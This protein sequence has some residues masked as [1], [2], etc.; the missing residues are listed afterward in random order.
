MFSA[1]Y[2]AEQNLLSPQETAELLSCLFM[3][4]NDLAPVDDRRLALGILDKL[5]DN[6]LKAFSIPYLVHASIAADEAGSFSEDILKRLMDGCPEVDLVPALSNSTALTGKL[7]GYIPEPCMENAAPKKAYGKEDYIDLERRRGVIFLLSALKELPPAS[8]AEILDQDIWEEFLHNALTNRYGRYA[9]VLAFSAAEVSGRPVHPKEYQKIL[10][11]KGFAEQPDLVYAFLT[12]YYSGKTANEIVEDVLSNGRKILYASR[13]GERINQNKQDIPWFL[14]DLDQQQEDPLSF[15]SMLWEYTALLIAIR[16]AVR[17]SE[18]Y[19]TDALKHTVQRLCEHWQNSLADERFGDLFPWLKRETPIYF[20]GDLVHFKNPNKEYPSLFIN[21]KQI[22]AFKVFLA[23]PILSMLILRLGPDVPD[24]LAEMSMN[25]ADALTS[26]NIKNMLLRNSQYADR[27]QYSR[28]VL[29][30]IAFS[31]E[32]C[33]AIG[34]GYLN[35]RIPSQYLRLIEERSLPLMRGEAAALSQQETN[36]HSGTSL[37]LCIYMAYEQGSAVLPWQKNTEAW[38]AVCPGEPENGITIAERLCQYAVNEFLYFIGQSGIYPDGYR[39]QDLLGKPISLIY[40]R[41]PDSISKPLYDGA[42]D[43]LAAYEGTDDQ[44][45]RLTEA[46]LL[47]YDQNDAESWRGVS[48]S[49]D[50]SDYIGN[51]HKALLALCKKIQSIAEDDYDI[52]EDDHA[53]LLAWG[54]VYSH[55]FQ[56]KELSRNSR[57]LTAETIDKLMDNS[58]FFRAAKND[59]NRLNNMENWSQTGARDLIQIASETVI[60]TSSETVFYQYKVGE[61]LLKA[62]L[63]QYAASKS[64]VLIAVYSLLLYQQ[65]NALSLPDDQISMFHR[66]EIEDAQKGRKQILQWFIGRLV[67]LMTADNEL[68]T[69]IRSLH[70]RWRSQMDGARK[71]EMRIT[72]DTVITSN[73][74]KIKGWKYWDPDTVN[75]NGI[76]P[77]GRFERL[78]TQYLEGELKPLE[79]DF[80]DLLVDFCDRLSQSEIKLILIEADSDGLLVS[81]RPGVNYRLPADVWEA[82]GYFRLL[83]TLES[84]RETSSS[85]EGLYLFVTLSFD[86]G[87]PK[88]NFIRSDDA[89]LRYRDLFEYDE[90]IELEGGKPKETI[91]R[92]GFEITVIS[93]NGQPLSTSVEVLDN[94]WSEADRR[95][96]CITV[97]NL[98]SADHTLNCHDCSETDVLKKYI[99]LARGQI[100]TIVNIARPSANSENQ[101]YTFAFTEEGMPVR[102]AIESLALNQYL[103]KRNVAR[104]YAL[105]AVTPET[106]TKPNGVVWRCSDNGVLTVRILLGDGETLELPVSAEDLGV[107]PRSVYCGLPVTYDP[108]AGTVKITQKLHGVN[109]NRTSR[110]VVRRLWPMKES[111]GSAEPNVESVYIGAYYL[112]GSSGKTYLL[113]DLRNGRLLSC[114]KD[115]VNPPEDRCGVKMAAG[116]V[117]IRHYLMQNSIAEFRTEERHFYG[118]VENRDKM[119]S[120]PTSYAKVAIRLKEYA[121]PDGAALF[122]IQRFYSEPVR[123]SARSPVVKNQ[124][125][126]KAESY[127]RAYKEWRNSEYWMRDGDL[128]I[129]GKYAADENGGCFVPQEPLSHLPKNISTITDKDPD[130]WTDRIPMQMVRRPVPADQETVFSK[131]TISQNDSYVAVPE[132][133]ARFSLT[134]LQSWLSRNAPN[135]Q[136]YSNYPLF[137]VETV[138]EEGSRILI[139]ELCLGFSIGVSTECFVIHPMRKGDH[140]NLLFYGDSLKRYRL[141]KNRDGQLCLFVSPDDIQLSVEHQIEYDTKLGVIQYMQVHYDPERDLVQPLKITVRSPSLASDSPQQIKRIKNCKL[142]E[143]ATACVKTNLPEGGD[144]FLTVRRTEWDGVSLRQFFTLAPFSEMNGSILCLHGGD[145]EPTASENDYMVTFTPSPEFLEGK[146]LLGDEADYRVIVNRRSFSYNEGALRVYYR[147][148]KLDA[149]RGDMLVKITG[150]GRKPKT[151]LGTLKDNPVHIA[152]SV[153]RWLEDQGSQSVVLGGDGP[154]DTVRIEISPGVFCFASPRGEMHSGVTG[155]LF[156]D[157]GRVFAEAVSD[158]DR[159]FC[160]DGRCVDLLMLDQAVSCQINPKIKTDEEKQQKAAEAL[161]KMPAH[162]SVAGLPQILIE[163]PDLALE[164]I[165]YR[166][167]RLGVLRKGQGLKV[168]A[169]KPQSVLFGCLRAEETEPTEPSKGPL[170]RFTMYKVHPE[171]P[172]RVDYGQISFFDGSME[173]LWQHIR[174]GS[175]HYHDQRTVVMRRNASPY[176]YEYGTDS[177]LPVIMAPGPTLR[178]PYEDLAMYAFPPHEPQEYGL[179]FYKGGIGARFPVA[180]CEKDGIYVEL[181]P[182]RIVRFSTK[183]LHLPGADSD[184]VLCTDYLGTGD[185][186]VLTAEEGTPGTPRSILINKI[187]CG[188]RGL[189]RQNAYLPVMDTGKGRLL[190]GNRFFQMKYPFVGCRYSA[191]DVLMIDQKNHLHPQPGFPE[192]GDLVFAAP[193]ENNGFTVAGFPNCSASLSETGTHLWCNENSIIHR[194]MFNPEKRKKLFSLFGS[195]I[196]M[197]VENAD[198]ESE[199]L[200]LSYPQPNPPKPNAVFCAQIVGMLDDVRILMRAGAFLFIV[201]LSVELGV[202]RELA[203]DIAAV[204]LENSAFLPGQNLWCQFTGTAFSLRTHNQTSPVC[205]INLMFALDSKNGSGFLC[206]DIENRQLRWLPLHETVYSDY[207]NARTI[208]AV[209]QDYAQ[210]KPLKASISK[211]GTISWI[212]SDPSLR[213]KYGALDPSDKKKTIS[214][215]VCSDDLFEEWDEGNRH[216]YLCRERP[217]GNLYALRSELPKYKD[218][219]VH[220]VCV[221][222]TERNVELIPREEQRTTIRLS[223]GMIEKLGQSYSNRKL[224]RK[225]LIEQYPS[226]PEAVAMISGDSTAEDADPMTALFA[227]YAEAVRLRN[228]QIGPGDSRSRKLDANTLAALT[229]YYKHIKDETHIPLTAAIAV[230]ALISRQKPLHANKILQLLMKDVSNYCSEAV[231]LEEWMLWD[232]GN[233]GIYDLRKLLDELD[234]QGKEMNDKQYSDRHAGTLTVSQMDSL[235]AICNTIRR[236]YRG[237]EHHDIARVAICLQYVVLQQKEGFELKGIWRSCSIGKIL[238]SNQKAINNIGQLFEETF[239]EGYKEW[240]SSPLIHIGILKTDAFRKELVSFL[241]DSGASFSEEEV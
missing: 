134:D 44:K 95:R 79:L 191:G 196:P 22:F 165:H 217:F 92:D 96:R 195:N 1:W 143:A 113:Q 161:R 88:L 67:P 29:A 119:V 232:T 173:E 152:K 43:W 184:A 182:G 186:V 203:V 54:E 123:I 71:L 198:P 85:V 223:P 229:T 23:V 2:A 199:T 33:D 42:Q 237:R 47:I 150:D 132:E 30:L 48:F 81:A 32:L 100:V 159:R 193:D 235:N 61:A 225:L 15:I 13:E 146:P 60:D 34:K 175:W 213:E 94:T 101:E 75:A 108:D 183:M 115:A 218:E 36:L 46:D 178:Y 215:I 17:E 180:A 49:G 192:K 137:Y 83:Q 12:C 149:F 64:F 188:L 55:I 38:Y 89:N 130:A 155:K 116:K 156:L 18:R 140:S 233:Y 121:A 211:F 239:W 238:F 50:R 11:T 6:N 166:P 208:F 117:E 204:L 16:K 131:L 187:L 241:K 63:D 76:N 206:R 174:R 40:E 189:F 39:P 98:K 41:F 164:M 227:L 82:E 5:P 179:P 127:Y 234:L 177:D 105:V 128:Y 4:E 126:R 221:K 21:K 84:L 107:T 106:D 93:V 207:A 212:E 120:G 31:S 65:Q 118:H 73:N 181:S 142:D 216:L 8:A 240:V 138:S 236:R 110:I 197:R 66:K 139:F 78:W 114:A 124:N 26:R 222:K 52:S 219:A 209:L 231:L 62:D 53:A 157:N 14:Q 90:L 69:G 102:V 162:F 111:A 104:A 122:D 170:H 74:K 57:F 230:I 37:M 97:K 51:N 68:R 176:A 59:G 158:E 45:R 28:S 72:T 160:V 167:P 200:S 7:K 20:K 25:L 220:A 35:Y 27:K 112:S 148:G 125:E 109:A 224:N 226:I 169:D 24:I 147:T 3:I 86:H 77:E 135:T 99:S 136:V 129:M 144:A 151:K 56:K 185:F 201:D 19:D 210:I 154:H 80:I 228:E 168:Y 194:F 205:S 70:D 58:F 9:A 153:Q 172:L 87:L 171:E 91:V 190:F 141:T 145:I 133:G 10:Q 202:S 103:L 214:V 163:S